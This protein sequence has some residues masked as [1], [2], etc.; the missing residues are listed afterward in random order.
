MA[1]KNLIP[2]EMTI[3]GSH[4]VQEALRSEITTVHEVW[5]SSNYFKEFV[6]GSKTKFQI[7][8]KDFL[9]KKLNTTK[10]QGVGARVTLQMWPD[11]NEWFDTYDSKG[12]KQ[13]KVLSLDQIEDPQNL[14][15]IYR[16]AHFFGFD[17]M[18]FPKDHTAAL[19]G[20]VAKASAGALFSLPTIRCTNLARELKNAE[21]LGFWRVGLDAKGQKEL[22]NFS[23]RGHLFLLIGNEGQGLRKLTQDS[24]DELLTISSFQGRD[25]L[26]ASVAAAIAM[27]EVSKSLVIS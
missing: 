16:S 7:T 15:A 9:D 25:S 1:N 21:E 26:N 24:C 18:V 27:Y 14:G 5:A 11:L 4:C 20:T 3:W 10:H 8:S 13:M 23:H 17:A 12:S 22:K 19:A 2:L 6:Q